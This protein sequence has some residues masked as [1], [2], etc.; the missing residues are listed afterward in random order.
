M[1]N[2]RNADKFFVVMIKFENLVG[3]ATMCDR[4]CWTF[5]AVMTIEFKKNFYLNF[6]NQENID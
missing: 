5:T 1:P 4:P 6:R 2:P 3:Q